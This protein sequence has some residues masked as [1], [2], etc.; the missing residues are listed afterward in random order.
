MSKFIETE[1]GT[2]VLSS[3]IVRV[4]N[5]GYLVRTITTRSGESYAVGHDLSHVTHVAEFNN[6]SVMPAHPGY[7]VICATFSEGEW[8][9]EQ[10]PVVGWSKLQIDDDAVDVLFR[11]ALIVAGEVEDTY[12]LDLVL[13]DGRVIGN[14]RSVYKNI[15]E[16]F[17]NEKAIRTGSKKGKNGSRK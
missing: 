7:F 12:S 8:Q 1:D 13:P 2:F 17:D 6:G 3:E 16:W 14:T 9:Y 10:F 15:E 4:R 11:S 5:H